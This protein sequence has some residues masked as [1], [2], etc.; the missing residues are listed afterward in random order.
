MNTAYKILHKYFHHFNSERTLK[1]VLK[2]MD[3]YAQQSITEHDALQ[4]RKFPENKPEITMR[5]LIWHDKNGCETDYWIG[6][7]WLN[8]YDEQVIAFRELPEPYEPK[9]E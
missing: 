2:A 3:E 1:L 9:T 7:V 8:S 4:W 6:N 5:Y